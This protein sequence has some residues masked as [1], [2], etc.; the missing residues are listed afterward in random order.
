MRRRNRIN[1]RLLQLRE[2]VPHKDNSNTG[3]AWQ[4]TQKMR[5]LVPG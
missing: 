3:R 1:D 2:I 4:I 5:R